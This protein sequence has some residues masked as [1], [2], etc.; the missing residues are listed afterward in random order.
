MASE[1]QVARANSSGELPN[2]Q[3]EIQVQNAK[4]YL[5]QTSSKSNTNL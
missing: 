4:A 5:L 2:N 3:V 1:S